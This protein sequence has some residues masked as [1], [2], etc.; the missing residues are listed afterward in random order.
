LAARELLAEE[1]NGDVALLAQI[2]EEKH[3]KVD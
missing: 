1:L 2:S 3:K